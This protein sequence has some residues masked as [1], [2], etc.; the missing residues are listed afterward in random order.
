MEPVGRYEF[1]EAAINAAVAALLC[2]RD[3]GAGAELISKGRRQVRRPDVMINYRGF[4]IIIEGKIDSPQ[5]KERL[6][7]QCKERISEGLCDISVGVVYQMPHAN[8][9]T[10]FE[11]R[12]ET[13]LRKILKKS[14]YDIAVWRSDF[15]EPALVQGWITKDLAG[16]GDVIRDAVHEARSMDELDSAVGQIRDE[17]YGA[18]ARLSTVDASGFEKLAFK[19]APK[20]ELPT[21]KNQQEVF[22]T[23][24]IAFLVLLDAAVFYNA[25]RSGQNLPSVTSFLE[26]HGSHIESLRHSFNAALAINYAPVFEVALDVISPLTPEAEDSVQAIS[27]LAFSIASKR[28]LLQHDLMGRIYH[29]LLFKELAKHLATYYTAITSARILATLAL[30]APGASWSDTDLSDIEELKKLRVA[31]FA[32]GSGTLL[33]AAHHQLKKLYTNSLYETEGSPDLAEVHRVLLDSVIT[34]YDVMLY[35]AHIATVTLA[36][37]NP[38]ATFKEGHIY[39]LPFGGRDKATGS[40][41]FLVRDALRVRST[42]IRMDIKGRREY[43]LKPPAEGFD[44]LIMNPPFA[45]SC[46]DNLMF[47]SETDKKIRKEMQDRLSDMLGTVGLNGIGQAGLGAAF[48]GLA[49]K[50]VKPGGRIAFVL[51]RNFLS[52]VSWTKI[53]DLLM[54]QLDEETP[55]MSRYHLEFVLLNTKPPSHSFSENTD[56]S[57]VMFVARKLKPDESAGFTVF[58]L[59]DGKTENV[60]AATEVAK[61]ILSYLPSNS[62]GS[63]TD[64]FTNP[65]GMPGEILVGDD[66]AGVAYSAPPHVIEDNTA[67]WGRLCAFAVPELTKISY[68]LRANAE[69]VPSRLFSCNIPMT[70]LSSLGLIGFDTHQIHDTFKIGSRGSIHAL[71]GRDKDMNTMKTEP[72]IRLSRIPGKDA[73][74]ILASATNLAFPERV[75]LP[76]SAVF[77][78]YCT[79]SIISN[80]WWTI[81]LQGQLQNNE[82]QEALCTWLNSTPAILMFLLDQQPTRGSWT[83]IKKGPLEQ[84]PVLDLTQL[85]AETIERMA[86]LFDEM[87]MKEAPRLPE[88]FKEAAEGRGWRHNLDTKLLTILTGEEVP[89]AALRPVYELLIEE[90]K[91]W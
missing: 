1:S 3:L 74:K 37:H 15:P 68:K 28:I 29:T 76:T 6:V 50:Y 87:C 30:E 62:S 77:C 2:E 43:E 75:F 26:R 25:I 32:C 10:L 49:N 46:G 70:A 5:A 34:G 20:L 4:S 21:P 83:R 13:G 67:N 36:M 52:G 69:F 47:G 18:A 14:K 48:V 84:L 44:L 41:E 42:A 53:R 65:A 22:R 11:S 24:Q 82:A 33:S 27:N 64:V 19:L 7:H 51:P 54:G 12:T 39:V 85:S 9:S 17:L 61:S 73:Q 58:A 63:L 31:D 89:P 45:R 38:D 90:T 60:V 16:L 81:K 79:Q 59:L 57:E 80:V 88:Q 55:Y 56:L 40:L 66:T 23:I 35:A 86:A 91:H 72:N 78:V 71:W 8:G